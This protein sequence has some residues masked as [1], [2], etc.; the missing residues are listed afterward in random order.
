MITTNLSVAEMNHQSDRIGMKQD[1]SSF[2][3]GTTS[4]HTLQFE[5]TNHQTLVIKSSKVWPFRVMAKEWI[6]LN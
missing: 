4:N 2:H 6:G 5:V 1:S 3:N